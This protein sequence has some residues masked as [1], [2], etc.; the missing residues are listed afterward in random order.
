MRNFVPSGWSGGENVLSQTPADVAGNPE[1]GPSANAGDCATRDPMRW[2]ILLRSARGSRPHEHVASGARPRAPN[3]AAVTLPRHRQPV[4]PSAAAVLAESH[5]RYAL[6]RRGPPRTRASTRTASPNRLE[7]VER[8]TLGSAGRGRGAIPTGSQQTA[9]PA[10]VTELGA[11]TVWPL[12]LVAPV[13]FAC[14]WPA[15][16]VEL[17]RHGIDGGLILDA[18][19]KAQTLWEES[20][21]HDEA[22]AFRSSWF[23]CRAAERATSGSRYTRSGSRIRA[24]SSMASTTSPRSRAVS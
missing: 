8:G 21:P 4:L 10:L 23:G 11:G 3:D 17:T 16:G 2:L 9:A 1:S 18:A 22:R 19:A 20:S 7:P 5:P 12:S 14:E 15:H 24:A 6:S 13:T